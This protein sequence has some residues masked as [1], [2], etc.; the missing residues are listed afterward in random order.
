MPLVTPFLPAR[1]CSRCVNATDAVALL[2]KGCGCVLESPSIATDAASCAS[3]LM[4]ISSASEMAQAMCGGGCH[5]LLVVL[6]SSVCL[7]RQARKCSRRSACRWPDQIP[8]NVTKALLAAGAP[9]DPQGA[10]T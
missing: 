2:D 9:T 4:D 3:G 10:G 6:N 5:D 7:R 1:R 8:P